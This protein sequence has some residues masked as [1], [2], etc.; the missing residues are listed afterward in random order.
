MTTLKARND[1]ELS[2]V[3]TVNDVEMTLGKF[4]M[5]KKST[6]IGDLTSGERE[7]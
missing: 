6:N 7:T 4:E 2:E 3:F 5:V 1:V